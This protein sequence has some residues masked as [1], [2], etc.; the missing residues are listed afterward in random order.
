MS[1]LHIFF[2]IARMGSFWREVVE[3][4]TGAINGSRLHN[5]AT[6]LNAV[7]VGDAGSLDFLPLDS[8]KWTVRDG[9]PLTGY[10]FPTVQAVWEFA[11]SHPNDRILY[12]H[13]KGVREERGERMLRMQWRHWMT[14]NVVTRWRECVWALEN[15]YDVAGGWWSLAISPHFSGNFWWANCSY[16]RGLSKPVPI[17]DDINKRV[18]A[19]LWIGFNNPQVY[20]FGPPDPHLQGAYWKQIYQS[21][22]RDGRPKRGPECLSDFY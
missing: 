7:T 13:T 1:N 12:L 8:K 2:H 14:A 16:L 21:D 3:G 22:Y 19:E 11:A 20:S 6:S 15:G 18:W 17:T 9:G 5:A 4:I 10:E